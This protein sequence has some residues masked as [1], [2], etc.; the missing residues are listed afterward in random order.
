MKKVIIAVHG[1]GN[2]PA[3][4]VLEESWL[5][6]IHEGLDR[7]G[8]SRRKIP[9]KMVYWADIS[10]AEPLDPAVDDPE[11][12][13]FLKEPYTPS[14][15]DLRPSGK[16]LRL[17]LYLLKFVERHLDKLFLRKNMAE[18]FPSA[19]A[20]MMERYFAD[21]DLYYTDA[22]R[23]LENEDC[24]A[25]AAIQRR[26]RDVLQEYAGFEILLVAHSMGSIIAFDVL[27]P[28]PCAVP[29]HTFITMG[30]PLGLPPI[31]ARNFQAQQAVFPQLKRP[32]APDC[33]G[34]HWYN[35]SDL[36]DTVALDHTLHDDYATNRQGVR[37]VDLIVNNDYEID[38]H[39]NPHKSFGYLRTPA[40]AGM[41]DT[42]LTDYPTDKL[43]RNLHRLKGRITETTR[44]LWKGASAAV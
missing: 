24:S 4:P 17:R 23:S 19:S 44:R 27:W 13:W 42:F 21:L 14:P 29:I 37:A 31:V 2:K 10:H 26:L 9:F 28:P 39:A 35:L 1:L 38:G 11:S 5:K 40:V 43:A 25:K 20:K 32:R 30:S 34:P 12:P 7:I 3:A 22:C 16:P 41:I 33:V 36:G 6:A 15:S 18:T 8:K